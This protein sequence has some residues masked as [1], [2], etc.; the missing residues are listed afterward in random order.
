MLGL[1]LNHVSKR[2]HWWGWMS[3]LP[4]ITPLTARFMWPTWCP[5]G[6]N[7]PQMGPML[8]PWTLLYGSQPVF[9][10][11]IPLG[12][13]YGIC[14]ALKLPW[15]F[16]GA[17]LIFNGATGN[18]QGNIKRYQYKVTHVEHSLWG[19]FIQKNIE[20][21]TAHT[22]VSWPNPKQYIQRYLVL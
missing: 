13:D 17:P 4:C 8:V 11:L 16:P 10:C 6:A 19:I 9:P 5:S 20:R 22:I 18:I 7:R 1:K 14:R 3:G 2:G 21:H 12:E 15:I